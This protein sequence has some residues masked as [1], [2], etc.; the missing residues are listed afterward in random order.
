MI[1]NII[2]G[3]MTQKL[4]KLEWN[5]HDWPAYQAKIYSIQNAIYEASKIGKTEEIKELQKQIIDSPEAKLLSVKKVTQEN[6]GKKTPGV[7]GVT[8][9]QN[10][11]RN[12]LAKTL[13]INDKAS[14]IRRC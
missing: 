7:D 1:L 13:E 5:E 3:N 11:R 10:H 4:Y 8:V 6:T 12:N 2:T 9:L 14:P